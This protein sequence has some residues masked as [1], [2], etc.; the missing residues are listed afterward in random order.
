M[1]CGMVSNNVQGGAFWFEL[2]GSTRGS[3]FGFTDVMYQLAPKPQDCITGVSYAQSFTN[4]GIQVALCDASV[5]FMA[6]NI[7]LTEWRALGS[8]GNG[9]QATP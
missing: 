2:P 9:D 7:G 8:I 5:H 1:I 6:Q 3:Y 4:A